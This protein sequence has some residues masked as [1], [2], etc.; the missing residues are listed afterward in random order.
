M[1][2]LV[3]VFFRIWK[4]PYTSR[5]TKKLHRLK[6]CGIFP[7]AIFHFVLLLPMRICTAETFRF[8]LHPAKYTRVFSF[9]E[10]CNASLIQVTKPMQNYHIISQY[11]NNIGFTAPC[12]RYSII[13]SLT[14]A[15]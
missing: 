9:R 14:N 7:R 6:D 2:K 1:L 3:L 12:F 13:I 11:N 10:K 8:F 5:E 4:I 15:N